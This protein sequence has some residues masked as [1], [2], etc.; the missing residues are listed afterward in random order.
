MDGYYKADLTAH[1]FYSADLF[2][3]VNQLDDDINQASHRFNTADEPIQRDFEK[4]VRRSAALL[5]LVKV[6]HS[7]QKVDDAMEMDLVDAATLLEDADT[8]LNQLHSVSALLNMP[9]FRLIKVF[10]YDN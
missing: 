8:M 3:D 7:L 10:H 4:L 2:E 9:S 5:L 1:R 6:H